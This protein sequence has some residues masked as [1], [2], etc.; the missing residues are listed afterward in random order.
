MTRREKA[1]ELLRQHAAAKQALQ[2]LPLLE[3]Q[4]PAQ[5]LQTRKDSRSLRHRVRLVE[6]ALAILNPEE[7]LVL[8]RFFIQPTNHRL[9]QLRMELGVEQST[10]YRRRDKALTKF[11]AALFGPSPFRDT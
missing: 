2:N 3:Q 8:H 11:T 4:S 5:R 1:V 10:V 9:D 7:R 6:Q